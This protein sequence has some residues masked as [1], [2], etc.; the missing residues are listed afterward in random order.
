MIGDEKGHASDLYT[1]AKVSRF[2]VWMGH[3]Q[4]VM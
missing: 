1:K 3:N 4:M 2:A